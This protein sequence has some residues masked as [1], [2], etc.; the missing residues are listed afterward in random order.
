MGAK[1]SRR[2]AVQRRVASV[3]RLETVHAQGPDDGGVRQPEGRRRQEHARARARGRRHPSRAE[4]AARRLRPRSI[5]LRRV[6][7]GPHAREHRA[8]GRHPGVQEPEKAA[9][10]RERRRLRGRRHPWPRRRPF[11]RDRRG[12]G[13]R[14]PAHRRLP[15]RSAPDAL[16]RAQA[17]AARRRRASRHGAVEGRPVGD[18]SFP[19]PSR[20]SRMRASNSCPNTG[21]SGTVSRTISTQAAPGGK[22]A[23]RTCARSPSAWRTRSSAAR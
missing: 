16:P 19:K 9:Q 12:F 18:S 8:R 14:V 13:C 20:R 7:R 4:D 23:I 5:D 11:D 15:G 17:R 3:E 1:D 22:R 6:E 2:P 21:R 10:G